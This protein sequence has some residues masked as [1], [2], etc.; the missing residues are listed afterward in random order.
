MIEKVAETTEEKIIEV[1]EFLFVYD[2]GELK[3][4]CTHFDINPL[5]LNTGIN[6]LND[7]KKEFLFNMLNNFIPLGGPEEYEETN[8]GDY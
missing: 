5:D 2:P 6:N 4:I 3:K 7:T 1:A 8:N